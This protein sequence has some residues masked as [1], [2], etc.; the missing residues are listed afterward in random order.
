MFPSNPSVFV[1]L[2]AL[3]F[4]FRLGPGP[5]VSQRKPEAAGEWGV[6]GFGARKVGLAGLRS[7][8]AGTV[9]FH[10]GNRRQECGRCGGRS[11]RQAPL[12]LGRDAGRALPAAPSAGLA[13][14]LS[15][16]PPLQWQPVRVLGTAAGRWRTGLC[17]APLWLDKGDFLHW[18]FPQ[19][20]SISNCFKSF[21]LHELNLHINLYYYPHVKIKKSRRTEIKYLA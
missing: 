21:C 18:I 6:Q 10:G 5:G 7:V 2:R 14:R 4:R 17:P 12:Q 13:G 8:H 20:L 11:G 9:G 15:L 19:V 3:K 1:R 16:V